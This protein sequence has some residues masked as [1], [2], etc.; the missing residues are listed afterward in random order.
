MKCTEPNGFP[1]VLYLTPEFPG[2][3]HI[4]AWREVGHLRELGLRVEFA[5]TR[6]PS[7]EDV[8]QHDFVRKLEGSIFYLWPLGFITAAAALVSLFAARPRGWKKVIGL[9]RSIAA[10]GG[11][12]IWTTLALAVP[13]A[14][15]ARHCRRHGFGHVHVA[16]AANGLI[17]ALL[18]AKLSRVTV[19]VTINADLRWWGGAMTEKLRRC[20]AIC[21]VADWML[22]QAREMLPREITDRIRVASHGVDTRVWSP[23]PRPKSTEGP[24]RIV[25]VGRLHEQKGHQDLIRAVHRLT[26]AGRSVRLDV[27]G[28]GPYER[29]LRELAASLRLDGRTVFFHGAQAESRVREVLAQA[30]AFACA[31]RL[32]ALGVVFMEAMAAGIPTIGTRVGGVPEIIEDGHSGLL[33]PPNDPVSLAA[34]IARLIDE[35]DLTDRLR[36]A[37]P[38]RIAKKF[39]SRLGA[40]TVLEQIIAAAGVA[41]AG[42]AA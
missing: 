26:Q 25:T 21:V 34:A 2:H 42:D 28:R 16:S 11:P 8:A 3:T 10:D 12:P 40:K 32:E 31:T 41:R 22:D 5:S 4:W 19:G 13:A 35:P 29:E 1:A 24:F 6:R 33:V 23:V 37:G 18:G 38:D 15:L 7:P 20:E 39:D 9:A 17:I 30:D 36:A 27:I 14:H